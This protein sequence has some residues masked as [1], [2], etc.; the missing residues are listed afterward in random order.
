MKEYDNIPRLKQIITPQTTEF[1]HC[2]GLI[3]VCV[4]YESQLLERLD[5][6]YILWSEVGPILIG[7]GTGIPQCLKVHQIGKYRRLE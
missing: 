4:S 5:V 7:C 1:P 3:T 2:D 6:G